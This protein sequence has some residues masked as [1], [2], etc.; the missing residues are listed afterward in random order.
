MEAKTRA[1]QDLN[2]AA[3]AH[4]K[5]KSA[6]GPGET[7]VWYKRERA[8]AL[9]NV[10]DPDPS[11]LT[12]THALLGTVNGTDPE[13]LFYALQGEI[14]S[15]KGEARQLVLGKGL[16]HTSMSVGDVLVIDD[17]TLRCEGCGFRAL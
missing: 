9:F 10:P 1:Y 2:E 16:H 13:E 6:L 7:Q 15:P 3:L 11:N 17:Q 5:L 4:P 8:G 12:A 14:W